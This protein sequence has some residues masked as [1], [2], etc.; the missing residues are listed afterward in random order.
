MAAPI[1]IANYKIIFYNSDIFYSAI[2]IAS[3]LE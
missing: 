2:T 3:V 1:K